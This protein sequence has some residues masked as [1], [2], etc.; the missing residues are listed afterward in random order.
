MQATRTSLAPNGDGIVAWTENDL[1]Y[2]AFRHEGQHQAEF[3]DLPGSAPARGARRR[4]GHSPR[5]SVAM[6][7]SSRALMIWKEYDPLRVDFRLSPTARP[8]PPGVPAHPQSGYL[9]PRFS[10][11]IAVDG[12]GNA[13]VGYKER[14]PAR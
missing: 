9:N 12:A 7:P 2:A 5:P 4:P 6:D 1:L 10:P 3:S 8:A 13:I 14:D 11:Q